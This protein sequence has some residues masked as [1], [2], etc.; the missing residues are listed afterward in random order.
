MPDSRARERL[1]RV[2]LPSQRKSQSNRQADRGREP[3]R[4]QYT[5]R[6]R[7][8]N[9]EKAK[10]GAQHRHDKTHAHASVVMAPQTPSAASHTARDP[11]R[12][13]TPPRYVRASF[14]R[15]SVSS[16]ALSSPRALLS[17]S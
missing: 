14:S 10:D 7:H 12:R 16:T 8:A 4:E 13:P 2:P 3:D 6:N 15:C 17:V 1:R 5:N 9:R 11:R